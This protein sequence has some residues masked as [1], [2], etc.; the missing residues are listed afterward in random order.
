ML[1]P[2]FWNQSWSGRSWSVDRHRSDCRS[3]WDSGE[4][5]KKDVSH[6]VKSSGWFGSL[7][8]D[9]KAF[10][11][12]HPQA[13]VQLLLFDHPAGIWNVLLSP[14]ILQT[15]HCPRC[16]IKK[17]DVRYLICH[18]RHTS[19]IFITPRIEQ[20]LHFAI[21]M[22][23]ETAKPLKCGLT[24][25]MLSWEDFFGGNL[26]ITV[27]GVHGGCKWHIMIR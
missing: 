14:R 21:K 20:N 25:L 19:R 8:S 9:A 7:Q 3:C 10:P 11:S 12:S 22:F 5:V 15:P 23:M 16:P 27:N 6:A 13:L 2:A 17:R 18:V 26:H 24:V 4:K 1:W